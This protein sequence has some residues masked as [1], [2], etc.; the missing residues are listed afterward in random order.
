MGLIIGEL[1]RLPD[2]LVNSGW[3]KEVNIPNHDNGP[4][5][6]PIVG[7]KLESLKGTVLDHIDLS[8][9][10]PLDP[11]FGKNIE[12]N[13]DSSFVVKGRQDFVAFT[14]GNVSE[15]AQELASFMTEYPVGVEFSMD[16]LSMEQ[17]ADL[18]G[19]IGKKLD[20]AF[21]SGEV[22]EQE[23]TDLNK[24]LDAYTE[25]MT[26]KAEREKAS[27]SVMK[28][29][30]AAT[31]AMIWSGTSDKEMMDYTELVREKWQDKISEY[32]EENSYDRTVLG[33]MITAIR[34]GTVVSFHAR[35]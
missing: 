16:G 23:Y 20:H 18:F 3:V 35:A 2:A 27:C 29:T 22:S 17:L 30:A 13:L 7:E 15:K 9:A 31:K 26:G 14:S 10:I 8:S 11:L 24:G 5:D 21:A 32:L 1:P 19:G 4:Q 34:T 28:Q 12:Y 25:F 6:N 33:E